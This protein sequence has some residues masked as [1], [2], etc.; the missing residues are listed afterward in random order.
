MTVP[1]V[2]FRWKDRAHG[3]VAKTETLT[4]VEFVARYLRHVLPR[5][6][7]AVRHYGFCHPSAAAKRQ[8]I[9]FHTGRHL[10]IAEQPAPVRERALRCSCCGA[11]LRLARTRLASWKATRAPPTPQ[12]VTP[13]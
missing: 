12:A 7:K 8:R 3:G 1:H 4:G 11:A 9:A 13:T 6:L 2:S 5:G 10:V